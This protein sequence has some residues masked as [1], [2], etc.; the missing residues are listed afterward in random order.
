MRAVKVSST[1]NGSTAK[2]TK[3]SGTRNQSKNHTGLV[4]ACVDYLK[5]MGHLAWKN[6]TAGIKRTGRDGREFWTK[7]GERGH[8]DIVMIGRKGQH[9]EIECKTGK[10]KLSPVQES[11][12]KEILA[13][14]AEHWVV[15][16]I[17]DL[18][19]HLAIYGLGY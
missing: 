8:G 4:K 7:S 3:K 18:I 19:R 15:R 6:P 11:R 9:I 17:D 12:R 10:G 1:P 5:V 14:G 2:P 16:S 13:S